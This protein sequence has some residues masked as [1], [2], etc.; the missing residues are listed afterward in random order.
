MNFGRSEI[1]NG[2]CGVMEQ[3]YTFAKETVSSAS[4]LC[5]SL[6]TGRKYIIRLRTYILWLHCII[7]LLK[8]KTGSMFCNHFVH[9]SE[10]VGKTL[11]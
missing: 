1:A 9:K 6:V 3:F 4:F 2:M 11:L 10:T 8:A 7:P 5:T